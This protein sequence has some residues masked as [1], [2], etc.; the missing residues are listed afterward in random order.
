[1]KRIV[2]IGSGGA[3]KTSLALDLGK[4]LS[5]PV[6]HLDAIFWRRDWKP[7]ERREF[8]A[9]QRDLMTAPAWVI[10]GN[11]G[12]TMEFRLAAADTIIFMDLPRVTCLWGALKRRIQQR[13]RPDK[14]AENRERLT[15]EYLLWIWK[16]RSTRR[17]G[18]LKRLEDLRDEK[19]IIILRSRADTAAF[20]AAA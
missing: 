4:K 19:T 6:H 13:S 3:G 18:I 11:Y 8:E 20:L 5:I 10:D 1:L 17:P 7:V 15:I 16:Y 12:G 14:I 9:A 2:I